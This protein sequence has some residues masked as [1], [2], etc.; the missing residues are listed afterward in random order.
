MIYDPYLV[1]EGEQN[2]EPS[3][4]ILG[5]RIKKIKGP[6]KIFFYNKYKDKKKMQQKNYTFLNLLLNLDFSNDLD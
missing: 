6:L 5:P 1:I 3:S 2:P 4:G